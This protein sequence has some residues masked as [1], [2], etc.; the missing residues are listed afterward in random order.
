MKKVALILLICIYS[1]ATIGFSINQFYCCGKLESVSVTIAEKV[2]QKCV[3]GNEK[4]GCCKN[5]YQFLKLNDKHFSAN[6][7]SNPVKYIV[8]LHSYSASFPSISITDQ[9]NIIAKRSNAP[10]QYP[11][12]PV[13][14]YNCAFR[15]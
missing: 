12:V 6:E 11:G 3:P 10:P 8:D 5:K 9:K 1:L 13:Y 14:I 2:Q 7:I 15:I 4:Q